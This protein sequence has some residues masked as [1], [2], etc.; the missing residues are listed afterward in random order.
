MAIGLP[1]WRYDRL[2]QSHHL[3]T[4]QAARITATYC[5]CRTGSSQLR[6]GAGLL[7]GPQWLSLFLSWRSLFVL[8]ICTAATLPIRCALP[9]CRSVPEAARLLSCL[10]AGST[11]STRDHH[12]C[13]IH[14]DAA[15]NLF[16]AAAVFGIST[17]YFYHTPI[18]TT[19]AQRLICLP[20]T[21][22]ATFIWLASFSTAPQ[23][24]RQSAV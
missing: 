19:S 13:L 8:M 24:H 6:A 22:S 15:L 9:S 23:P 20:T 1:G 17:D 2:C 14:L 4:G 3:A 21:P 7:H 10:A 5:W 16:C 18:M 12:R 11:S